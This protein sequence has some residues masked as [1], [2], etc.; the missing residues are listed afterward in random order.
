MHR[1]STRWG[2]TALEIYMPGVYAPGV[3]A[4]GVYALGVYAP[5]VY[6]LVRKYGQ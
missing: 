3:Y 5:G 2:S 6:A 1:G 4:P